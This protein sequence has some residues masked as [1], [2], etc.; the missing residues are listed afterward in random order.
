MRIVLISEIFC[1]GMGY[2]ENLLPKYLVRQ[3]A[4]VDVVASSLPPSHRQASSGFIYQGFADG[5]KVGMYEI[6]NGFRVHILP[7]VKVAGHIRLTGLGQKLNSLKP[8]IVQTMTP[9]G[10]IAVDASWQ[11]LALGYRLFSGCHHHASVFPL[12]HQRCGFFSPSRL[13]CFVQRTIHGRIASSVTEKYYAISADC[14]EIAKKF[15]GVPENKLVICPLGVDTEIFHLISTPAEEVARQ[16]LRAS[17]GFSESDI[18]CIY[19]GRFSEDKNPLLLAKAIAR[20]AGKGHSFKAIFVGNG[21]QAST[22]ADCRGCYVHPFA[23]I[24][25]LGGLYRSAEIGVWPAQESMS[26]LDAAACGLPIIANDSMQ[27]QERLEGNG[28]TYRLNDLDDLEK[29]LLILRDRTVRS[30]LGLIGSKKMAQEYSWHSIATRRLQDYE[31]ALRCK[32]VSQETEALRA[33]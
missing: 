5:W 16:R 23:P 24:S 2:L 12:A 32:D 13:K 33:S 21:A 27:A 15:F 11:R 30:R 29:T 22:I 25:E 14:A 26:M 3:G 10:W 8:D 7:P 19:S 9:I 18:V 20:L 6:S 28:M 1:D 31:A 4:Q 17:F